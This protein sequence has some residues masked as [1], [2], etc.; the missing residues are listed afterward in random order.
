[1]R[2]K[3]LLKIH[4]CLQVMAIPWAESLIDC[5]IPGGGKEL[6]KSKSALKMVQK[7]IERLKKRKQAIEHNREANR[8]T[9]E[10]I[11]DYNRNRM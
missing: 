4:Y 10:D 5:H 11:A 6:I 3:D 8:Q 9:K 2:T 7:D 1:M